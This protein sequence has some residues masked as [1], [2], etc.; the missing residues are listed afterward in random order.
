VHIHLD[1]RSVANA[2]K[3]VHFTCFDHEDVAGASLE[4]LAIHIPQASAFPDELDF[5]IRVTMWSWAAA[6]LTVEEKD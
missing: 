2:A 5:V 6:G 4:L 1:E 3:T